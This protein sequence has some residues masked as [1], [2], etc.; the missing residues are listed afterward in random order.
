MTHIISCLTNSYGRFGAQAAIEK[1]RDAGI[2]W[3]ELPIRTAGTD[4]IFGDEPLIT[5]TSSTADL[6]TLARRLDDHGVRLSSCNVTSGNPLDPEVLAVTLAKLD[7]AA[8]LGVP[9]VVGGAGEAED[10]PDRQTLFEHLRRIGDHAASRGLIYCFETHPGIC[11]DHRGMYDTMQELEHPQL[12][13]NFDTGN[14]LY[15]N[16]QIH[17]EIALAKV[18]HLVSHLHLKDSQGAYQ[19]WYFPALGYGGAVDFVR[20]L[21]LM[22]ACG[23]EGPY[24][25]EIEGIQGEEELSLE[26]H[27][28]RIVDSVEHLRMCGFLD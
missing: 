9:L 2:E 19:H 10:E 28:R 3:I 23:F 8:D 18:C 7:L 5:T 12:R 15:Y 22:S 1:V 11:Q 26:D 21:E 20:V 13:L 25:L 6:E 17:G 27:H 4:S 16:E 24:S 14:I